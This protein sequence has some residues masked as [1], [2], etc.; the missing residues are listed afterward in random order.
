MFYV[1]PDELANAL[2]CDRDEA[3]DL[4]DDASAI[5][6]DNDDIHPCE[7][8]IDNSADKIAH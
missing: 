4:I 1:A 5:D 2:G 7:H 8:L 6:A 3:I